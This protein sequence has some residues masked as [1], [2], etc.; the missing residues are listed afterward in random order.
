MVLESQEWK[1]ALHAGEL[2]GYNRV[3]F[4]RDGVGAELERSA[5]G[6]HGLANVD[7]HGLRKQGE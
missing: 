3:V 2:E 4:G 1:D 7:R 5:R 6:G